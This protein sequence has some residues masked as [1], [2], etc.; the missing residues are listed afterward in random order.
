LGDIQ[1]VDRELA[2]Y[3]RL[4]EEL[5]EPFY[6]YTGTT[7]Q[8]MRATFLGH[9]E[10]GERLAQQA[11]A[12]GQ[13]LRGQDALGIF[14]VQMFTLRRAQGRLQE[15]APV[16]RH[17]VQMSPETST[18]R[19]G[20][21]LIYSELGLVEETRTAFERLAAYDFADIP[22]DARWVA[23]LVYL[24]EVCTFLG[25]ARRAA[26]LYQGLL[27][28]DGYTLVVGPTAA[29]YGAAAHYLGLLA[30]TMCRWE[31]AHRHF[32]AALA[33]NARMGAKPALAH[34]QYAYA[35]MLLDR[36]QP[37]DS[38]SA[39][40]LLDEALA[41]S[42]ELGMHTLEERVVVL[43]ARVRSQPHNPQPYPCGLTQREVE[44]LR[45]I[46]VGKS[47]RDIAQELF[48]SPNTVANHVRSILTKTGTANRTEAAAYARR[49]DLL[50]E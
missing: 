24:S 14:G 4:V 41:I 43:R 31:E 17:F 42:L 35:K 1:A 29:C 40:P 25:D 15:L 12:I 39:M 2:G 33:M 19:P 30:A 49:H 10:E 48:V 37:D 6:L 27:P 20:L 23:C 32:T 28:H 50:G 21:A 8:A 13:R 3:M 47:N 45:L 5:R 9:F 26:V 46:A 11:L 22:R 38:T 34:T 16:V 36:A 18:W 7:F 44:V